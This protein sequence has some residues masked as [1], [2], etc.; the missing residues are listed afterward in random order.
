MN[1]PESTLTEFATHLL[2]SLSWYSRHPLRNHYG[3]PLSVWEFDMFEMPGIYSYVPVQFIVSR[4][5]SLVDKINE[6][7]PSV[8]F[9]IPLVDF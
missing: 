6:C 1:W 5:V 8:L 3:K 7:Y 2:V 4:M 9:I